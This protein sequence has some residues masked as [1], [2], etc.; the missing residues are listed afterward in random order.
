M[1]HPRTEIQWAAGSVVEKKL[2]WG[3]LAYKVGPEATGTEVIRG[4]E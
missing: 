1:G 2:L 3:L 4:S